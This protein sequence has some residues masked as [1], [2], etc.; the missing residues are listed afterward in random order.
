LLYTTPNSKLSAIMGTGPEEIDTRKQGSDRILLTSVIMLMIFGILAVYSSIAYFAETR[1]TTAGK[2]VTGHMIK[3]GIAFVVMLIA[4]KIN[5]RNV[6]RFSRIAVVFSWL[7]LI[8]VMI[9]GDLVFGARRS[10]TIAGFSFQPSSVATVV[11]LMHV[12]VLLHEKQEYI[13]DFKRSFLPVMFWIIPTCALIGMEDF[14]SAALLLSICLT[15][16]FIG[17]ISIKHLGT[18]ILIGLIGGSALLS[19]SAERQSRVHQYVNQVTNINSTQLEPGAGYQAQQAYIAIAQ[20]KLFGVGIGKSTQ[21][22]FLPAPYNDFI[23]SIIAEEYGIAGAGMIIFLYVIILIRGI[24]FIARNA[25]DSLGVLL[26][27]ACTITIALYGFVNAGVASGLLP[28]TGLPMPFISY[29][30]TSMLF[31]ALMVGILLNISK[32]QKNSKSTFYYG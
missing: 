17:R 21:R 5:Y 20:G 19:A 7:L 27:T 8:A 3:L 29:G 12:A 32:H 1:G 9:Y 30:G 14:S 22:D 23:Y 10:L 11:L 6:V 4:S 28:V 15:L 18:L 24:V 13:K 2:L 16:M 25:V 26:A 31:T